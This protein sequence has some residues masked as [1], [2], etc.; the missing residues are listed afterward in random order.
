MPIR[1]CVCFRPGR[2]SAPRWPG[3]RCC[4]AICGCSTS[5]MPIS[6]AMAS[7]SSTRWLPR[8]SRAAGRPCSPATAQCV[9]PIPTRAM[10][11]SH[12]P[13]E[14]TVRRRRLSCAAAPRVH[15][16][17]AATRRDAAAVAV[18]GDRDDPVS[19]RA[20]AGRRP[21]GA[22]Q[23]RRVAGHRVAGDAACAGID[24]P[25]R[26]GRRF[27]GTTAA[28]AATA[29]AAGV[30]PRTRTL[31]NRRAAVDRGGAVACPA[32]EASRGCAAG[33]VGCAAAG[34]AAAGAAGCDPVRADGRR[35]SLGYTSGLDVVAAGSSG[36]DL[37]RGR[38]GR[39][40]GRVAVP[41]PPVVAGRGLGTGIGA[42]P[43]RVRGGIADR[44]G[45]LKM[46]RSYLPHWMH[47]LGSP[48]TFY[49]FAGALRP[50][51]LASSLVLA[52]VGIYG[53]LVLAP[54]DYQQGDAYRIIFIHVPCAW[55]SLF[56]YACMAVAA[57]AAMVWRVKLA[58]V[59]AMECAP[60]GAAFTLVTLITGSLWGRPMW[61]T[62]W[63][64]DARLTSELVL[65]F[66]FLGVI[67]LF[68]AIED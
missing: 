39:G 45:S 1:R 51:L 67:G 4:R 10:C 36:S 7:N 2:R 44:G 35:A 33:T 41:R 5:P 49:R 20:R 31:G 19:I 50:W 30:G 55:M 56:A 9:L 11:A 59:I 52:A 23:W 26:P 68:N 27:T 16:G 24:V 54:T 62:W 60:V 66:L 65:L 8:T 43:V 40:A 25:R 58:E 14:H 21:A 46:S 38:G 61:G 63:T 32:V 37:R 48:P 57:L 12:F 18:R 17:V 13:Y 53:G 47:L 15:V 22:H 3:W 6:T 28:G 42:C 29:G 34:H 64:W